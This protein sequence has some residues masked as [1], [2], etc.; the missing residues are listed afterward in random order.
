MTAVQC[1]LPV[2][3]LFA[4]AVSQFSQGAV[5]QVCDDTSI[6]KIVYSEVSQNNL[7]FGPAINISG[8]GQIAT[9][10]TQLTTVAAGSYGGLFFKSRT[11]FQGP[12][13][14]SL[15]F[16]LQA[17][18]VTG[19]G[20]AW[21]LIIA[22]ANSTSVLAPPYGVNQSSFGLSGWS[23]YNALVVEFDSFNSST[24]EADTTTLD[25]ISV[26][27]AGTEQCVQNM[28][29]NFSFDDG[30]LYT[31]WVDYIGFQSQLD[32]FISSG[33]P[34]NRPATPTMRCTVDIW[35][36]LNIDE[37]YFVGFA[38]YNPPTTV[39]VAHYLVGSISIADAYRPVDNEDCAAYASCSEKVGNTLCVTPVPET[40]NL[41]AVR[42]CPTTYVWS[43]TGTPE[44]C[45]FIEKG[46]YTPTGEVIQG[47]NV[48]CEMRRRTISF[49]V[50]SSNCQ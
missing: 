38:A 7:L 43:V 39:G 44:C 2:L 4:V 1:R 25:H 15:K 27:L 37:P 18:E 28:P 34:S 14:F 41:C 10:G 29:V 35:G 42:E 16:S 36:V 20:D 40:T 8:A 30:N 12:G 22:G 9:T 33:S 21:E 48:T 49:L 50:D 6:S 24:A 47:R 26:F 19:S 5:G 23:R 17:K 11:T 31:M 45:A 3:L 13:G 32:I 46:S